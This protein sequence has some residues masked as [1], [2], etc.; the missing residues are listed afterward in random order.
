MRKHCLLIIGMIFMCRLV[1]AQEII[2]SQPLE[3]QDSIV[4]QT[5]FAYLSIDKRDLDEY[6]VSL[7]TLLKNH[8]YDPKLFQNIQFAQLTKEDVKQHY[9]TT[10]EI[11]NSVKENPLNFRYNE[12]AL[13]WMENEKILLPYINEVLSRFLSEG[14]VRV[15]EKFP[16]KIVAPYIQVVIE[17]V[18]NKPYRVFKLKDGKDI[19][20]ETDIYL[21]HFMNI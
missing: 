21:E 7:D 6:L 19:L 1:N 13:F 8:D 20:R 17:V 18:N 4:Y 9:E 5:K 14:K 3:M 10:M 2:K 12:I 16:K 15:F 11:W